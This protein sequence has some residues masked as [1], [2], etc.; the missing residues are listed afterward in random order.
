[1]RI[2]SSYPFLKKNVKEMFIAIVTT[3]II[4]NIITFVYFETR[5]D[6]LEVDLTTVESRLSRKIYEIKT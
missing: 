5:I 1:M 6:K 2:V 3:L 4:S